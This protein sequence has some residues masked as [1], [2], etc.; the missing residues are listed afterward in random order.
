MKRFSYLDLTTVSAS[1]WPFQAE[2]WGV[3]IS[4]LGAG[5]VLG[6]TAACCRHIRQKRQSSVDDLYELNE[7]PYVH[8]YG[9]SYFFF[10]LTYPYS[11]AI[12]RA[13]YVHK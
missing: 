2:N 4:V 10:A 11:L 8:K 12:K 3:L 5:L 1:T 7:G 6:I 13:L 9:R